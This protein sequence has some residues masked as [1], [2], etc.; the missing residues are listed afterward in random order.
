MGW[1]STLSN[2][3]TDGVGLDPPYSPTFTVWGKREGMKVNQA[4][5]VYPEKGSDLK[6]ILP[7]PPPPT[8]FSQ[9]RYI[10]SLQVFLL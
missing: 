1:V 5:T 2:P 9:L 3:S 8:V 7:P 10:F 6:R 4:V